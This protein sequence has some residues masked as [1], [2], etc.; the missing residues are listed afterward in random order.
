MEKINIFTGMF[1]SWVFML[2]M[3]S[4]VAFQIV[5]VEFLGTFA[6]T[7]PLSWEMWLYSVLIGAVS[8]VV[9]VILKCIPVQTEKQSCSAQRHDGYEPLP[10]GPDMV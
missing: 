1:D 4:T 3:V 6:D 7:V 8:L 9:G 10:S 5:I 2:V